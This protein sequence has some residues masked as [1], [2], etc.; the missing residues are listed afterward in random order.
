MPYINE[1][2]ADFMQKF[3]RG[4]KGMQAVV[5]LLVF[6]LL[7]A[8]FSINSMV[9]KAAAKGKKTVAI[10]KVSLPVPL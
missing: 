4:K 5:L 8:G 7:I 1:Q 2:E 6:S 9:S 10:K 3:R